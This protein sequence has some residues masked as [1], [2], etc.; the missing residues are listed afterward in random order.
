MKRF[1]SA[2]VLLLLAQSSWGASCLVAE[3]AALPR[4]PANIGMQIPPWPPLRE[5]TVTHAAST[6]I[7]NPFL[8]VTR[9]IGIKC[10]ALSYFEV[11]ADGT[12]TASSSNAWVNANEWFFIGVPAGYEIAFSTS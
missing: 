1:I 11:A 4:D 12:A 10:D 3:F 2:W 6:A 7:T 5:Q 9:Y 8:Q